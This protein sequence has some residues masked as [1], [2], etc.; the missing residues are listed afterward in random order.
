[1][2]KKQDREHGHFIID[3]AN[4]PKFPRIW[5]MPTKY[6]NQTCEVKLI[7]EIKEEK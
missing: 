2:D 3:K 1:M 6:F 5:D 4:S 7:E